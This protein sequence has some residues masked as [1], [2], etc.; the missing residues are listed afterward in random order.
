MLWAGALWAPTTEFMLVGPEGL[1]GFFLPATC[2]E[3]MGNIK[4][5]LLLFVIVKNI[6]KL[7]SILR[8]VL[9]LSFAL[10]F[11]GSQ[12]FFSVYFL[13][14]VANVEETKLVGDV[15]YC[16]CHI[17]KYKLCER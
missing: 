16:R 9:T 14:T 12:P 6:C 17:L 1:A 11:L 13:I 4:L 7:F 15:K 10:A 8:M 5:L 3:N 2:T